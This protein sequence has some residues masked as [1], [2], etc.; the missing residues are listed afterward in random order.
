M[1]SVR[2]SMFH[3]ITPFGMSVDFRGRHKDPL[4]QLIAIFGQCG[5]EHPNDPASDPVH[6]LTLLVSHMEGLVIHF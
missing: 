1:F 5:T 3:V 4:T 2:D 6:A